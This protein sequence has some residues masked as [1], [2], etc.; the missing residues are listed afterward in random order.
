MTI[1]I[2]PNLSLDQKGIYAFILSLKENHSK[3]FT[4][5]QATVTVTATATAAIPKGFKQGVYN[6]LFQQGYVTNESTRKL[7]EDFVYIFRKFFPAPSSDDPSAAGAA[8]APGGS[9]KSGPMKLKAPNKQTSEKFVAALAVFKATNGEALNLM[10]DIA[11]AI[12]QRGAIRPSDAKVFTTLYKH[13][14]DLFIKEGESFKPKPPLLFI[15]TNYC[16]NKGNK[17]TLLTYEQYKEKIE[18][19]KRSASS[20]AN[21]QVTSSAN[22]I[23]PTLKERVKAMLDQVKTFSAFGMLVRLAHGICNKLL[24]KKDFKQL[25]KARELLN[26]VPGAVGEQGVA[27]QDFNNKN[28]LELIRELTSIDSDGNCTLK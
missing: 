3:A 5:L 14:P 20:Q 15:L 18:A 28:I 12:V 26:G 21:V 9:K 6:E 25:E 4:T 24:H 27:K 17:C 8:K 10:I 19:Q 7:T 23:N 22:I 16:E 11:T 2:P 1:Q 13:N